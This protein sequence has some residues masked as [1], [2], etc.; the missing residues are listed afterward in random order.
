MTDPKRDAVPN[1]Y[2]VMALILLLSWVLGIFW[3]LVALSCY[4]GAIAI[5][6]DPLIETVL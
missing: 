3:F 1:L 6:L 2:I 4:W 5:W